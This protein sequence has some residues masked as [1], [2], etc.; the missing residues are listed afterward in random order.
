MNEAS[1]TNKALL[2][3]LIIA[4]IICVYNREKI[5][6]YNIVG[7]FENNIEKYLVGYQNDDNDEFPPESIMGKILPINVQKNKIDDLYLYLPS[8]WRPWKQGEVDTILWIEWGT[9]APG[10]DIVGDDKSATACMVTFVNASD[11]QIYGRAAF[12][13]VTDD[14]Q[15]DDNEIL[16]TDKLCKMIIQYCANKREQPNY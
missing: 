2:I 5:F 15:A 3:C 1:P 10:H 9:N 16:N 12:P 7:K 14:R 8:S 13:Q 11:M 4:I 6:R